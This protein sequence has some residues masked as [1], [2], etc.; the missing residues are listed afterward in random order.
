MIGIG[1]PRP[2]CGEG[3]RHPPTQMIDDAL[4]EILGRLAA[5]RN[6]GC[7]LFGAAPARR[8]DAKLSENSPHDWSGN[9]ALHRAPLLTMFNAHGQLPSGNRPAKLGGAY[10]FGNLNVRHALSHWNCIDAVVL[11][12]PESAYVSST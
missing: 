11:S 9:A 5:P 4:S 7:C 8:I 6:N 10:A 2:Q 3:L 1:M 12:G